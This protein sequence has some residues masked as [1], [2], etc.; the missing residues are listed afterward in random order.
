MTYKAQ[1]K[2]GNKEF[3]VITCEYELQRDVDAKGRPSSGIYGGTINLSIESTDDNS[4]IELMVNQYK[5]IDG[6]II[7]TKSNER[8]AMKELSFENGYIIKYLEKIDTTGPTSMLTNFVISAEKI[9]I[10]NAEHANDWPTV[11]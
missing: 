7:F 5:P 4:I 10:G 11:V 3:N 9:K 2:I 1:L 6:S 8:Y